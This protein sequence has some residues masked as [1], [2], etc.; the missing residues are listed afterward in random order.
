MP[1]ATAASAKSFG[2]LVA[3]ALALPELLTQWVVVLV[4][5]RQNPSWCFTTAIPPFIPA[6]LAASSHCRGL[7]FLVGANVLSLSVPSPHSLPV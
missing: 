4:G 5:H 1:S 6:A 2:M 7:G 3:V